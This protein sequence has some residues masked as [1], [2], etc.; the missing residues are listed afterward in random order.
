M[1]VVVVAPCGAWRSASRNRRCA[2]SSPTSSAPERRATAYGVFGA[3]I[4]VATA[5]GGAVTG[6][7]YE[8]S[9]PTLIT[10]VIIVQ[11]VAVTFLLV[12]TTGRGRAPMHVDR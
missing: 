1:S 12:T 2:R 3:V 11:L 4:G 5:S 7:L 6:D 10:T 8:H 9:I